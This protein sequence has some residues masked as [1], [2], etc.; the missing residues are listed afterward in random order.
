MSWSSR[1]RE[2]IALGMSE[3][4]AYAFVAKERDAAERG[5]PSPP[6]PPAVLEALGQQQLFAAPD[7]YDHEEAMV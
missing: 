3:A 7:C 2:Y 1:V 6:L 5:A 4:D